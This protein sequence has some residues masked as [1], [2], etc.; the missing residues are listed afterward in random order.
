MSLHSCTIPLTPHPRSLCSASSRSS[1]P[2]FSLKVMYDHVP[3][4]RYGKLLLSKRMVL[5]HYIPT[6]AD[7]L[8]G[9]MAELGVDV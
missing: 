3:H 7:A 1:V 6:Q 2:P 8:W 4:S 9:V 5:D